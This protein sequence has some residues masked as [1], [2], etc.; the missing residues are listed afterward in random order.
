MRNTSPMDCSK[1]HDAALSSIALNSSLFTPSNSSTVE[2]KLKDHSNGLSRARE[3][4]IRYLCICSLEIMP[5]SRRGTKNTYYCRIRLL[6]RGRRGLW[7]Q[8]EKTIYLPLS[9][10]SS[11]LCIFVRTS[12]SLEQLHPDKSRYLPML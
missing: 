2:N 9:E 4:E 6:K 8:R 12:A 5:D 7:E 1:S 3:R 10:D 11:L